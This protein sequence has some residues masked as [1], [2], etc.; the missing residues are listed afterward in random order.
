MMDI[1]K[2]PIG[3]V[4]E[5][6]INYS[7]EHFKPLFAAVETVILFLNGWLK[8]TLLFI[9]PWGVIVFVVVLAWRL[10]GRRTGL[11]ALIGLVFLWNL[12]I[13]EPTVVTLSL[14][15]TAAGL[16]LIVAIPIGILMAESR[17]I[18]SILTPVLDF[19]QTMPRF[20]YL[21]PGVI[22]FGIDTVPGIIATMT[23]AIPPPVR[24][25]AL[26]LSQID[27]EVIEA[28]EAFGCNRWKLLRKVKLPLAIPSIMLGVNQ[29]IMMS[30]SMVVI[31]AMIG[32]GGLGA[33]ILVAITRLRA[34]E[35]LEAGLGVVVIAIIIDS[36]S[37]GLIAKRIAR[38]HKRAEEV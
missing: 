30:L 36:L 10:A 27:R 6:I 29:C 34:G 32:A 26:G 21:I 11:F 7:V 28:G 4:G 17:I 20:I 37:R 15:I 18:T 35:G 8:T 25:T 24:L 5:H 2:I 16:S 1:Y 14:V 13:W 12:R 19:L 38:I 23:L 22:I 31:A 3:V 33:N 9:P